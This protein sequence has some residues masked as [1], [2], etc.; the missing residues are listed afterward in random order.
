MSEAIIN[1]EIKLKYPDHYEVLNEEK[2]RE[3]YKNDDSNRWAVR[4]TEEHVTISVLWQ[5][6]NK[7]L[8]ALADLKTTAKRNE[9]LMS[10][11]LRSY[12]Y[13]CNGYISDYVCGQ[14][15][16]GYCYEY[17]IEGISQHYYYSHRQSY[18]ECQRNRSAIY[19]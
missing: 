9:Q 3:L 8:A 12:G 17:E 2:L 7:V 5:G 16:Q 11:G 13:K 14:T 10:N 15:A 4:N 19:A 18:A 6:Y 1:N